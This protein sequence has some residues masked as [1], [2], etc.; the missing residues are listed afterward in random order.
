MKWE[1]HA[2]EP[3]ADKWIVFIF[4]MM[5]LSIGVHLLNLLTIPAIVMVY[6]FKR[7]D[8]F[9]Y[10]ILRK[11][12]IRIVAVGGALAFIGALIMANGEVN[13]DRGLSLDPTM[14][15]LMIFGKKIT[16]VVFIFS[17]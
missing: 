14:G 11:W 4:F 10:A 12:F 1:N 9:N 3:G 15:G 13:E 5:G 7:K 6:Y 2:D 16:M 17:S 8:S